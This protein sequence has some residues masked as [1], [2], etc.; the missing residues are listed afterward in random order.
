[1]L[2][3][4]ADQIRRVATELLTFH[5]ENAPNSHSSRR[6]ASL[7]SSTSHEKLPELRHVEHLRPHLFLLKKLKTFS[8]NPYKYINM[9]NPDS[10]HLIMQ[11][12][13][14][15]AIKNC[16]EN[17][18]LNAA[19]KKEAIQNIVDNCYDETGIIKEQF[20]SVEII[21]K[22]IIQCPLNELEK[23]SEKVNAEIFELENTDIA[24][25]YISA[26]QSP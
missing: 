17:N 9:N 19:I 24:C 5:Q 11:R 7:N 20:K 6:G 15:Q 10:Y 14:L 23:L 3:D 22:E 16:L 1:M 25:T 21:L 8:Y 13:K 2:Q 12:D 4:R 18:K 26:R